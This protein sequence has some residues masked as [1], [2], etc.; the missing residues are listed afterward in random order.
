M[1]ASG[2][3]ANGLRNKENYKV[4]VFVVK[5][6]TCEVVEIIEKSSLAVVDTINCAFK[7]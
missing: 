4:F 2:V 5:V 3:Q 6:T 7:I 1:K